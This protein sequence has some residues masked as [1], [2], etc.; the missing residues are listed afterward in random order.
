MIAI[1]LLLAMNLAGA[2]TAEEL[3][4]ASIAYHDPQGRWETAPVEIVSKVLL[5]ER[6][7]GERGYAER[8]DTIVVDLSGERFE[9][10]SEK[11]GDRIAMV[12]AG[13]QWRV[14]LNGSTEIDAEAVEKH[15]LAPARL[16]R[17]RDYFTYMF[18]LPMKLRDPGTQIEPE[19]KRIDFHGRE[20]LALRVTY[21]PEVGRDI[22]DFFFDPESHALIGCRFF[23][24]EAANDGEYLIFEEEIVGEQGLRLPKLRHWYMNRDGEHIATDDILSLRD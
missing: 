14:E 1:S 13:G 7:A 18:G 4:D 2:P 22:W 8:T 12:E 16:P 6:L 10:R 11:L 21:S 15:G 19:V 23:H 17:W 9:Y 5:T 20:V 3:L 24:D